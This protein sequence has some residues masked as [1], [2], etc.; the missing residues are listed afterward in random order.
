MDLPFIVNCAPKLLL[1]GTALLEDAVLQAL[2]LCLPGV[3]N[4]IR[5]S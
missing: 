4:N 1:P 2:L 5:G 3:A